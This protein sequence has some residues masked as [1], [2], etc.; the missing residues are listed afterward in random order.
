MR[1]ILFASFIA[2]LLVGCEKQNRGGDREEITIEDGLFSMNQGPASASEEGRVRETE[3]ASD[4]SV[5]EVGN[6]EGSLESEADAFLKDAAEFRD[7]ENNPDAKVS[8][9]RALSKLRQSEDKERPKLNQCLKALVIVLS[10][11]QENDE[12]IEYA[13]ELARFA[14]VDE[15]KGWAYNRIGLAC[16]NQA[17]YL[18]AIEYNEKSLALYLDS[19]GP[20]DPNAALNYNNLGLAYLQMGKYDQAIEYFKKTLTI[21]SKSLGAEH[22]EVANAYINL[23]TVHAKKGEY[24]KAIECNEKSLVIYLHA[25]GPDHPKVGMNYNNLG[26]ACVQ[27]R[28]R[29]GRRLF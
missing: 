18:K 11:M 27:K 5:A 25:K 10:E 26:L 24:A 28:L 4:Q 12:V 3:F 21:Y 23:G 9:L 14:T 17:E 2:L 20:D 7:Q 13:E 8:L 15:D 22:P 19:T 1:P 6:E 29:K 16:F